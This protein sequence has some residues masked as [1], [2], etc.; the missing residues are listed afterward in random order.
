[1]SQI[2]ALTR[3]EVV[4]QWPKESTGAFIGDLTL[5]ALRTGLKFSARG[6]PPV[7]YDHSDWQYK[8]EADW[9]AVIAAFGRKWDGQPALLKVSNGL[10]TLETCVSFHTYNHSI[11]V[12]SSAYDIVSPVL[13]RS[14]KL[15]NG[16][17]DPATLGPGFERDKNGNWNI[18]IHMCLHY[19]D[20][21]KGRSNTSYT[22]NMRAAVEEAVILANA[23]A[24][25]EQFPK[26][27]LLMSGSKGDYVKEAQQLINTHGHS[28]MLSIDGGFGPMTRAGVEWIQREHGL[29]VTGIITIDTWRVLRAEEGDP[30]VVEQQA[31]GTGD[32]PSKWAVE[33]TRWSIA[34]GLFEGT[35]GDNFNWQG[36]MTREQSAALLYRYMG[37]LGEV[38]GQDLRKMMVDAAERRRAVAEGGATQ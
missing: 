33:D 35:G 10:E 15:L 21:Y 34:A 4:K 22:R 3:A 6:S 12:A 14:K 26:M 7:N 11:R 13:Q 30:T 1:M 28:P 23:L 36:G 20:S 31:T 32:N 2:K 27:P 19:A 24:G 25:Q 8:T 5:T 16:Q 29:P 37:M 9:K 38:L 18:G 17:Y